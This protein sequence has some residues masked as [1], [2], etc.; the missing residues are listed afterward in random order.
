[1]KLLEIV[2]MMDIKEHFASMVYKFL[3]KKTGS[4]KSVN[5]RL[6]KELYTAVI[7]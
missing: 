4:G 1:M 7:K 6:A 3:D 5:E 2:T